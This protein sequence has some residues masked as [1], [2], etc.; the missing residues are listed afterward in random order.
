V[1]DGEVS[2]AGHDL[3]VPRAGESAAANLGLDAVRGIAA[4]LVVLGHAR[5]AWTPL[6]PGHLAGS[7]QRLALAP[8]AFAEEAVAVFF[9]LSGLLV[10][11][12]VL[13]EARGG[14]FSWR[15]FLAK[16]ISRFATV[17]VPCLML[18]G[19]LDV[20]G[21]LFFPVA[22]ANI[23]HA[24]ES[25]IALLCNGLLLQES[26]CFPFGS[27]TSLWSLSYEFW[28]YVLF[29]GIVVATHG[30]IQRARRPVAF[31]LL[32]VAVALLVFG[33]KLLVLFP[34]WLFGAA[35]ASGRVRLSHSTTPRRRST[36][37]RWS[38]PAKILLLGAAMAFSNAV[39][40]ERPL[41][42][43]VVGLAG[44]PL[45]AWLG[46]RSGVCGPVLTRAIHWSSRISFSLYAFHLVLVNFVIA[47][48]S[49]TLKPQ[50]MVAVALVYVV[51][52]A[53]VLLCVPLWWAT[54]RRTHAV[55][56]KLLRLFRAPASA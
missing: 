3:P 47:A 6:V 38:L 16:R 42:L 7:A 52:L 18:T 53:A 1:T 26:R 30:V 49:T 8:T 35:L 10:G 51:A 25:P 32:A 44:C 34:A 45:I 11:G 17:L 20:L 12:Q 28:F 50:G 43:V 46:S 13:R 9:V 29:A 19:A 33:P 24:S 4:L 48:L 41:Q 23:F 37:G 39:E 56:V 55:R 27:N 22:T 54:E 31:G 14:T 5:A 15:V 21:R 2:T 40:L 36:L